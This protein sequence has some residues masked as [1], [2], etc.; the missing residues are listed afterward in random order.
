M[1]F[2]FGGVHYG[3]DDGE[4]LGGGED[5][6]GEGRRHLPLPQGLSQAGGSSA[7][8]LKATSS[9]GDY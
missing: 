8:R 3:T 4:C 1:V 6:R 5:R 2:G 7:A 9:R